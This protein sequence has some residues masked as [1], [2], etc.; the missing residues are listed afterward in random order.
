[1]FL[2]IIYTILD[3]YNDVWIVTESWLIDLDWQMFNSETHFIEFEA[4]EWIEIIQDWILD[5]IFWKWQIIAQKMSWEEEFFLDDVARIYKVA[6]ELHALSKEWKAQEE[7]ESENSEDDTEDENEDVDNQEYDEYDEMQDYTDDIPPEITNK[8]HKIKNKHPH[9][10]NQN[11]DYLLE[12]LSWVVK[13]YM[14]N[15]W[16]KKD[17]SKEKKEKIISAKKQKWTIDLR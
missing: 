3:R 10:N 4:I 13:E 9:N 11:M 7:S 16:Y 14:T 6:D 2:R 12:V 8:I 5:N 15:S 17:D 1:M